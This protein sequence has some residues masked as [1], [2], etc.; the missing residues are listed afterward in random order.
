M[1]RERA[2]GRLSRLFLSSGDPGAFLFAP[3]IKTEVE[4][5]SSTK[6]ARKER[7]APAEP[8]LEQVDG[9]SDPPGGTKTAS[10]KSPRPSQCRN[11]TR[12]AIAVSMPA[13]VKTFV[14]KAEAGSVPH[15]NLLSKF[16]GFDHRPLVAPVKR[17]GKSFAQRLLEDMEE[18][19]AKMKAAHAERLA[20]ESA[21][22]K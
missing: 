22:S 3:Q 18:H 6:T 4:H 14:N 1:K 10:K 13:I 2:F 17:G 19:E 21:S 7:A 16:G 15:F 8:V 5:M 12:K 11:Y 9:E 20:A